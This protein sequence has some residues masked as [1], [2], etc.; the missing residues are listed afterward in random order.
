MTRN[1]TAEYDAFSVS[2]H[3][4][5]SDLCSSTNLQYIYFLENMTLAKET[6]YGLGFFLFQTIAF[7]HLLT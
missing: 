4:L 7:I 2:L 1:H 6:K 3:F 5:L